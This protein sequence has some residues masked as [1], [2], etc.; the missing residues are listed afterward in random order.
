MSS[1]RVRRL[2]VATL[3]EEGGRAAVATAGRDLMVSQ[4]LSVEGRDTRVLAVQRRSLDGIDDGGVVAIDR[5]SV[6]SDPDIVVVLDNRGAEVVGAAEVEAETT[7]S[8]EEVAGG[9][10]ES[11]LRLLSGRGRL[12]RRL[13]RSEAEALNRMVLLAL[14]H[15]RC[16]VALGL[17]DVAVGHVTDRRQFGAPIGSLQAVQHRLAGVKV[18]VE[19]AL[20]SLDAAWDADEEVATMVAVALSAT[21]L[22]EAVRDCLQVCGGMGFTN[23]FPLATRMRRAV[24]L[25]GSGPSARDAETVIGNRLVHTGVIR[26][27]EVD[28][29]AE[30]ASQ[31]D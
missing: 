21:A 30:G 12:R 1:R 25:Q 23:E 2:A 24:V 15:E 19:A 22:T 10:A 5:A 18:A 27:G 3:F 29:T 20:S 4:M 11:E 13:S 31:N 28:R 8:V 17:L 14:S 9:H 7:W 16:G 6:T 26:I